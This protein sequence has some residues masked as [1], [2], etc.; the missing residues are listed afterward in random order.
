MYHESSKMG[1]K[2]GN[3]P[4]RWTGGRGYKRHYYTVRDIAKM[5]GRAPGTIRNASAAGKINLDD[6]ESVIRYILEHNDT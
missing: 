1:M 4:H 3:I 5:T 2:Q 6:L